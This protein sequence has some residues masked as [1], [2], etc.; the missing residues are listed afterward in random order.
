MHS[1]ASYSGGLWPGVSDASSA[2]M[3]AEQSRWPEMQAP[4]HV[5]PQSLAGAA[6]GSGGNPPGQLPGGLF[7][8][9]P[10]GAG[11]GASL[12]MAAISQQTLAMNKQFR[13]EA[14][15]GNSR[16]PSPA[17]TASSRGGGLLGA[18]N[19]P[20]QVDLNGFT[21]GLE[22]HSPAPVPGMP[23]AQLEGGVPPFVMPGLAPGEVGSQ[24]D[25]A[26]QHAESV[27]EQQRQA[28]QHVMT[29]YYQAGLAAGKQDSGGDDKKRIEEL[30]NYIRAQAQEH[31]EA[32]AESSRQI[33]E[34]KDKC[35]REVDKK[36]R[37]KEEVER[38]ARQEILRLQQRLKE[39][40][41]T[42]EGLRKSAAAGDEDR[43]P[44]ARAVAG[45]ADCV[46]MGEHRAVQ[47]Q[48]AVAEERV[49]QLEVYIKNQSAK[50]V[51]V[52]P[53]SELASKEQENQNLRV[54]VFKCSEESE[55]LKQQLQH[56]QQGLQRVADTA[57]R[58]LDGEE[59]SLEGGHFGRTATKLNLT[60][61]EGKDGDVSLLQRQVKDALKNSSPKNTRAATGGGCDATRGALEVPTGDDERARASNASS[62]A[63]SPASIASSNRSACS[64]GTRHAKEA[65]EKVALLA[66]HMRNLLTTAAQAA[67]NAAHSCTCEASEPV[68]G[69]DPRCSGCG[70]HRAA[71]AAGGGLPGWSDERAAAIRELVE[72]VAPARQEAVGL[73]MSL[74]RALRDLEVHLKVNCGEL[75]GEG[76]LDK[77]DDSESEVSQELLEAEARRRLP[78]DEDG[79][80]HGLVVLRRAQLKSTDAVKECQQF[81]LKFKAIL[82]IV[83]NLSSE[84][85][86]GL[87][88]CKA[89]SLADEQLRRQEK[90]IVELQIARM[91]ERTQFQAILGS[92]QS[93]AACGWSLPQVSGPVPAEAGAE[94]Q[95][96]Q[97]QQQLPQQQQQLPV[98]HF[99][100]AAFAQM[101]TNALLAQMQQQQSVQA[102]EP[103]LEPPPGVMLPP[104]VVTTA[105]V[106]EAT[107]Q[108]KNAAA[109]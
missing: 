70:G 100:Q 45:W 37:E 86:H 55:L 35:Q 68:S 106:A 44:H 84:V 54:T 23:H 64:S 20:K 59:G 3:T 60:L 80:L 89:Y 72:R 81:P 47:Q 14:R 2:T 27:A 31:M 8:G 19:E 93:A 62:R 69:E 101:Q 53:E 43:S 67:A 97:Q 15:A 13:K 65:V 61:S 88:A 63:G 21:T 95:Q 51:L 92:L 12:S 98:G 34:A 75:L 49:R 30:T 83:K 99:D 85:N 66:T 57:E 79:Q 74:E 102:K 96:Q 22:A 58:F 91:S 42:D 26:R 9:S 73:L 39:H 40:G 56:L 10:P 109:S 48:C 50:S 7:G 11:G 78:L 107:K 105:S 16:S 33:A 29:M 90:Q 77:I 1:A 71:G 52:D 103:A 94:Q 18:E 41:E 32:Q 76:I 17:N 5:L 87:R 108:Q 24:A 6:A 104:G 38:Q 25:L 4:L 36:Q 46:L 28:L 82:D